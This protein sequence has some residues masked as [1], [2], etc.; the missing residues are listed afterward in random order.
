MNSVQNINLENTSFSDNFLLYVYFL[1]FIV[2]IVLAFLL[3][4]K[5]LKHFN[6]RSKKSDKVIFLVRLPKEKPDD[7]GRVDSVQQ[8]QEEIA[9]GETVFA[10]IGGLRIQRGFSAWFFG[11]DDNFSFEIVS[12]K[13]KISFYITAPKA[14]AL[15]LEQQIHAHYPEA[16]VEEVDDYNIFNPQ[17]FIS[18][19]YLKAQR[20]FIFPFLDYTEMDSDPMNSLINVMSK[21]ETEESMVVQYVVRS[22]NKKWHRKVKEA[23]LRANKNQD[24]SEIFRISGSSFHNLVN[25]FVYDIFL[26]MFDMGRPEKGGETEKDKKELTEKEREMLKRMEEKNSKAGLEVNLR[27]IVSTKSQEKTKVYF[28]N[29]SSAFS[30]YSYYEYGNSFRKIIKSNQEDI[31][32]SFIY[33]NF[34][35]GQSFLLNTEELVSMY[36]FPLSHTETPNIDWLTSKTA[37]APNNIPEEGVILGFNLFRGVRRDIKIKDI[38]RRRHMYIVGKSGTG[39]SVLLNN[40]AIQDIQRGAGVCVM[41]PNGDLI[42]DILNRIPP[43][44][45]EDVVIFSPSDTGRPLGLNLLEY[46]ERYPE[47]KTFVINEMIGIFDKLYD[48][49]AT[50]GPMFEQ[51]MRNALLLIM[52]SPETGSTLMEISKVLAD[53]DFR[54]MKLNMCKNKTVVDFWRKEAE[55]AGGDAALANMVPYITSKLT[56]F[57]SNDMMMPIIGQ[58]KSAFNFRDLMDNQKILMVDL[59]KGSIGETNAYLLG[60]IIVGKI[61]MAA[62][63]RTD[64][65]A[66]ERK[67]FYLYIDEFQNFTTNS[68]CQ[69]LSEARKYALS[70]NIAH[71]YIG[72]LSKSQDTEIKDAVFGNVGT[73]VS[74][75]VGSEDSEFLVKEFGP[76]FNEYDLVNVGRGSFVKLLVDGQGTRPFSMQTIWPLMGE[77]REGMSKNI[78]Q[79]SRYKYGQDRNIILREIA[80][81]S[82]D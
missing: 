52:D 8:V 12:S 2:F 73:M 45:S 14:R 77:L 62:L 16:S 68:V 71:Q 43:E 59:P 6:V 35:E 42:E 76:V 49:K 32:N 69:I 60:M 65:P 64:I 47:Q 63:S 61:L 80:G 17:G 82:I 74:F 66:E 27:V 56:P 26:G 31:I 13:N 44:R 38:D 78:R 54:R 4:R 24:V 3:L 9:K 23:V 51:Y 81:R 29:I 30:E 53:E 72:Q 58:Q 25:F 70:L 67:D 46:D 34:I 21:L 79:L 7:Q 41:D 22:A 48:L 55:K 40:L 57:V 11:R 5:I 28:D 19:G 37:P 10:S 36:H 75:R 15:Y 39:K 50:G 1:F 20:S 33:R 18:A